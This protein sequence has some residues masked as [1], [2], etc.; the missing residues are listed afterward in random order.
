MNFSVL[1]NQMWFYNRKIKIQKYKMA[2]V[3]QQG[4]WLKKRRSEIVERI[5]SL[6]N[7]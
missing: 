3:E 1:S 4:P 5:L 7:Y 6:L 2:Y